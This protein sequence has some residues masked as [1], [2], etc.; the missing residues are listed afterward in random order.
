MGEYHDSV[1][2]L[3][4][5]VFSVKS[6]QFDI[7]VVGLGHLQLPNSNVWRDILGLWIYCNKLLQFWGCGGEKNGNKIRWQQRQPINQEK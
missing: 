1:F 4:L 2:G 6:Y 3:F 5:A 7:I